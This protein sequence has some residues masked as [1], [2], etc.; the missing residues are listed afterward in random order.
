MGLTMDDLKQVERAGRMV[1]RV[2]ERHPSLLYSLDRCRTASD[3]L[4][5]LRQVSRQV[6][7]LD[8]KSKEY[9]S[10]QAM[11]DL[12]SIIHC[13][14][15]DSQFIQDLK[16]TLLIYSCMEYARPHGVSEANRKE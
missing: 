6:V 5:S 16:N 7:G 14:C 4:D 3:L 9:L 8:D 15:E 13:R 10:Y 11:E 2:S 12:C 1:A